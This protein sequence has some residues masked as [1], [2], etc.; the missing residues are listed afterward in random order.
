VRRRLLLLSLLT[1]IVP[2]GVA[3]AQDGGSPDIVGGSATT[4]IT[5]AP[6]QVALVSGSG[7]DTAVFC[8]G[9]ILDA[10]HVITAAH[11]VSDQFGNVDPVSSLDVVAGTD[12]LA[13]PESTRERSDVSAIEIH[14]DYAGDND[15]ALLTL[16]TP[17]TL[18][19]SK[20]AVTLAT[21]TPSVGSV[22]TVTGWGTINPIAPGGDNTDPV[23]SKLR[24]VDVNVLAD[25]DASCSGA[26]GFDLDPDTMVCAAASGK[27][28]CQGDSGGPLVSGGFLIGIVSFGDGCAASGFAGVYTE[29]AAPVIY[30]FLT[31]VLPQAAPSQPPSL[32]G[33]PKVGETLTCNHGQWSNSPTFTYAFFANPASPVMLTTFGTGETYSLTQANANQVIGCIVKATSSGGAARTEV[34]NSVGPIAGT[35]TPQPTVTQTITVPPPPPPVDATA[36]IAT[37]TGRS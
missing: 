14:P 27:D 2:T 23:Q 35:S 11:C 13:T 10:S 28:S 4:S 18:G 26:Y 37:V 36:P 30:E 12:D 24:E 29:V 32:T 5:D 34:S 33:T 31:G 22:A 9:S 7:P 8:G 15:V 25:N 6:Y 16:T 1:A 3:R 17:L 19:P 21:T 20:E